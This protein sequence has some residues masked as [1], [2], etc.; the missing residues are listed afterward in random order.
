MQTV[1]IGQ[2]IAAV[3]S[4]VGDIQGIVACV[5][6]A[7]LIEL[8]GNRMRGEIRASL[9]PIETLFVGEGSVTFDAARRQ[10]GITGTGRDGRTGTHLSAQVVARLCEANSASTDLLIEAAYT[11]RGPLAQFARGRVIEEFSGAIMASF[12]ANLEARLPAH[13]RRNTQAS[14]PGPC[15]GACSGGACS[16]CFA[17]GDAGR[18]AGLACGGPAGYILRA[19]QEDSYQ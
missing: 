11:L 17:S 14:A 2:P 15:S 10:A 6:G 18:R 9:G 4:A 5:P 13:R 16:H 12:V 7:R 1:R 3:W 8:S 19:G